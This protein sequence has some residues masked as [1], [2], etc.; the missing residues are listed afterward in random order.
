LREVEDLL[1]EIGA[2]VV[3]VGARE[4]YQAQKLVDDGIQFSVLMDPD[5]LV[6]QVMGSA[7]RFG[8]VRLLHPKGAVAYAKAVRSSRRFF[9]IT[10]SQATQRPGVVVLDAQQNV[11]WRYVGNRLGDYP[12]RDLVLTELRRAG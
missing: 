8:M 11:T 6:R 7:Q 3:V 2:N 1:A 12:D 9:D 4:V 5:N 10:L